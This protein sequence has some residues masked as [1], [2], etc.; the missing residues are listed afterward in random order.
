ML[1]AQA[2][3][4]VTCQNRYASDF[5]RR[6]AHVRQDSD[7]QQERMISRL[8]TVPLVALA[9]VGSMRPQLQGIV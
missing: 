2:S 1:P 6:W 5:V 3:W 8:S 7:Q 9:H 4:I